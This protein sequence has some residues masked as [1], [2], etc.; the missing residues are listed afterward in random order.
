MNYKILVIAALAV[1]FA[2]RVFLN[3][4]KRRSEKNPIPE[5]VSDVYDADTYRKWK[6]YHAE[7]CRADILESAVAF[8][9]ETLLVL[10]DVYAAFARLF[11]AG[12]FAQMSAVMLLSS[13]A[14]LLSVPVAWYD[15][16]VI[17]GKYGFNRSDRK[18]F[19]LDR[20]KEFVIGLAVMILLGSLLMWTH[21]ALGDLLIV[22]FAV[23]LTAVLLAFSFLY[24]FF[25]RIFNKFTP[26]E[27]GELKERLTAML[28]KHGYRVRA[29]QVMDASRRST[30]SNAYFTGF[31]KMK[32]IVLYDTLVQ[33]M[34]ADEICAVFAH[35]M[36]HGLNRDTLKS[37]IL[38]F[39]QM[40]LIGAM[41]FLILREKGI[42]TSCGFDGVNYGFAVTVIAAFLGVL[43]PLTGLVINAHSR[44]AEYRADA[45]AVREGYAEQLITGLKKLSRDNY[46]DLS[47]DKLLV[48]LTY[49]HPPLSRRIDAIRSRKQD[50]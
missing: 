13:L 11:P 50:R 8:A 41:A 27:D 9:A 49:S 35:E 44:R 47:P 19:V 22:A 2:C 36:G 7:K 23:L 45:Q 37:N 25:S 6:A 20:V 14:E 1:G 38:S 15:T 33:S 12:A 42:F 40:L 18:T 30:K 10:F 28:E 34:T 21:Q 29:I 5:N 3:L 48:K 16:M 39:F 4:L 26:L 17:E 24:P 46:A 31:G 43:S 32:T